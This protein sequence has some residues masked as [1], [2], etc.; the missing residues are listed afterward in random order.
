MNTL[1]V[2]L[3]SID[4]FVGFILSQIEIVIVHHLNLVAH[5]Y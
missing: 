1:H 5:V 3:A 4:T 2:I